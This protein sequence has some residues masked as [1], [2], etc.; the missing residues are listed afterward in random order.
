MVSES[1]ATCGNMLLKTSNRSRVRICIIWFIYTYSSS[2][3]LLI[4]HMYQGWSHGKACVMGFC[5][6]KIIIINNILL[7]LLLLLILQYSHSYNY[8]YYY[9]CYYYYY[10]YYYS[11]VYG[12][13]MTSQ[14]HH[15]DITMTSQWH[16]N[17]I[18]M[19]SQWHHNDNPFLTFYYSCR[20]HSSE[21]P[22]YSVTIYT[23]I[24]LAGYGCYV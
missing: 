23:V 9:Y 17:D 6:K 22:Q 4:S 21:R 24:D 14:W 2:T 5:K 1:Q 12:L 16:H 13:T 11:V 3:S 18:T 10:F 7:L 20:L 8:Y 15:N 19:T